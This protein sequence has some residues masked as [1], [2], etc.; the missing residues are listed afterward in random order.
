MNYI[1][2]S[3]E[4]N[5]LRIKEEKISRMPCAASSF[6]IVDSTKP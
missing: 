1:N 2:M 5:R 3:V 4:G 6:F